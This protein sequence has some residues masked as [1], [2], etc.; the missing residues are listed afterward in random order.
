MKSKSN[1]MKSFNEDMMF[2]E[3]CCQI[4]GGKENGKIFG[5]SHKSL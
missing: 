4:R 2:N 3:N 5:N 1:T